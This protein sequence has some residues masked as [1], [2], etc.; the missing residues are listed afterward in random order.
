[1]KELIK[2]EDLITASGTYPERLHSTELTIDIKENAKLL[3]EKVNILLCGLKVPKV[4]ISSGFRPSAV[5]ANTPGSA[6]RSAHMI[7]QAV[8]IIDDKDQTLGKLITSHPEK[9]REL[10]LFVE[11]LGSTRGK[12]TNW[13]HID[14]VK[15]SDRPSRT[16]KP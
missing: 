8:D 13:V 7:C 4:G 10:G 3:L 12:N 14:M 6:K 16:F 15:R 5:N 9:L 1:M 2:Y 11:D